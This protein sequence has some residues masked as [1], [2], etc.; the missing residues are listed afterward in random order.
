MMAGEEQAEERN[1]NLPDLLRK[2]GKLIFFNK[3]PRKDVAFLLD[4]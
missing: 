4:M 3:K 1:V 2:E